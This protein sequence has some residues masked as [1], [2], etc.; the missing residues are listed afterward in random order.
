MIPFQL[1]FHPTHDFPFP[2][3]IHPP[4]LYFLFP[5]LLS[6]A[7]R[8][9]STC[10][11]SRREATQPPHHHQTTPTPTP[12]RMPYERHHHH[13]DGGGE[14]H[15]MRAAMRPL[16]SSPRTPPT[17]STTA[18]GT[19][20]QEAR[21]VAEGDGREGN[22]LQPQARGE[23]E[24]IPS[25]DRGHLQEVRPRCGQGLQ[26]CLYVAPWGQEVTSPPPLSFSL[27]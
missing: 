4:A 8:H 2:P 23:G 13:K 9:V 5:S 17:P 3:R 18:G 25:R 6:L 20:R 7:N 19:H 10:K 24:G 22:I 15:A 27:N 14:P 1:S 21:G 11:S 26:G 16:A 12:I